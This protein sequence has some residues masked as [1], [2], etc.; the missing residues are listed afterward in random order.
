MPICS[1]SLSRKR[2]LFGRQVSLHVATP[3]SS[4]HVLH[5]TGAAILVSRAIKALQAAPTGELDCYL[6]SVS[7]SHVLSGWP[8][9]LT[10]DAPPSY[11]A[12]SVAG[13][14]SI[15][16][17][18]FV[19]PRGLSW[20][21]STSQPDIQYRG[22]P[23]GFVKE[24]DDPSASPIL[25]RPTEMPDNLSENPNGLLPESRCGEPVGESMRYRPGGR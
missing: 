16:D 4:N 10:A 7:S 1:N 22:A 17:A 21:T 9:R 11:L 20:I 15:S 2:T 5:L 3:N 12:P 25:G 23:P 24:F 8:R 18:T 13:G 14:L 19:L 6:C